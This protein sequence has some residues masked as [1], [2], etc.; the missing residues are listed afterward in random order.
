MKQHTLLP[1]LLLNKVLQAVAEDTINGARVNEEV[2]VFVCSVWPSG[3]V[4]QKNI[5]N[6]G[7]IRVENRRKNRETQ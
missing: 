2:S 3:S 5:I 1:S 7:E 4:V 6:L